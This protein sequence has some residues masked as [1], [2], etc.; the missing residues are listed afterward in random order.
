MNRNNLEK[1]AVSILALLISLFVVNIFG[2]KIHKSTNK[3][4]PC[5]LSI[6]GTGEGTGFALD[7]AYSVNTE[8]IY[9]PNNYSAGMKPLQ[10]T[11]KPRAEY[12]DEARLRC[13][14]GIVELQVTF[15][16]NGRTGNIK[17]LKG[18]EYGLSKKAVE[19]AKLIKFEPEIKKHRAVTIARKVSYT[20]IIY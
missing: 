7:N 14:D 20:F 3:L 17:I 4:H 12:T 6:Q 5:N 9:K 13:I 15:F 2:Q 16:A 18:L 11:S 19:A 8:T 1:K 10:I